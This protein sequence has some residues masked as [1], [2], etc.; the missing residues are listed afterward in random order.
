MKTLEITYD[1]Y[2]YEGFPMYPW[3]ALVAGWLLTDQSIANG[4]PKN[5][6][7]LMHPAAGVIG[8][9]GNGSDTDIDAVLSVELFGWIRYTDDYSTWYGASVLTVFPFDRNAG[10]GFALNYNNFKLGLTWHD[11]DDD[12]E[13]PTFFLGMD[14]YQLLREKT[15]QYTSYKE[16]V[17]NIL[18]KKKVSCHFMIS[19]LVEP[20]H[21]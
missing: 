18:R 3:E 20:L 6:I 13:N 1:K 16:K 17:T 15:R 14:F 2:L 11:Y 12:Y 19:W 8:A 9:A 21:V 7:V 5:Q 4:P 10:I